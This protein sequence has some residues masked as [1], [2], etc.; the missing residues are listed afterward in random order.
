[1][2]GENEEECLAS[3]AEPIAY[4]RCHNV[5]AK[6]KFVDG[7]TRVAG[8]AL[9]DYAMSEGADLMVM[10]AYGHTRLREFIFGGA[11]RQILQDMKMP[12]YMAH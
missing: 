6:A 2:V 1:M 3:A 11:T 5:D 10:G 8:D 4:L 9:M 12:V 7:K